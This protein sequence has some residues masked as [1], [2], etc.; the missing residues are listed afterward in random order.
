M[1]AANSLPIWARIVRTYP[2][3]RN[4]LYAQPFCAVLC[5]QHVILGIT[6]E[7]REKIA[8]VAMGGVWE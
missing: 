8:A 4:I 5:R 7:E 3:M 1:A 2:H 6:R